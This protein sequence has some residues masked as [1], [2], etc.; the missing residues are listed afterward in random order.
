MVGE[1]TGMLDR[2]LETCNR[3]RSSA[4]FSGAAVAGCAKDQHGV[5]SSCSAIGTAITFDVIEI[6]GDLVADG[7]SA[8]DR[9]RRRSSTGIVRVDEWKLHR[10]TQ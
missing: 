6:V 3:T 10:Q 7:E 9:S 1:N 4:V 2:G 8:R 5:K